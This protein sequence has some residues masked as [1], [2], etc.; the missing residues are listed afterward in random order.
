MGISNRSCVALALVAVSCATVSAQEFDPGKIGLGQTVV[1][2]DASGYETRGVVESVEPSKLVVK[3][4]RGRLL[5]PANP[6]KLLDASR[7][8]TPADVS[9]VQRPAPVWDGA[10]KGA[11]VALVPVWILTANCDC[12]SAPP[13]AVALIGGIGAAIG[14]GIDAAWGPKTLY[15][16]T[17]AR[18]TLAIAPIA[19]KGQRGV[20]AAIR[21]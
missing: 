3:Y 11:V 4:G 1:V 5:D 7:T 15:R 9:R 10:V 20:A 16:G 13:G 8:F 6:E 21:F 14:L 17:G 12:G 18:R 19:G 2:R